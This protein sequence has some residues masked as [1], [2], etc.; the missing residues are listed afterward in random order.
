MLSTSLIQRTL[1]LPY[2]T[3]RHKSSTLRHK[4]SF[5]MICYDVTNPTL[6]TLLFSPREREI[7]M[8]GRQGRILAQ[9]AKKIESAPPITP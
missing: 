1:L 2:A 6:N 4:S 3:L 9:H 8:G 7:R 5:V